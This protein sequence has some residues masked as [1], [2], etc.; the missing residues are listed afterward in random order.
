MT[1]IERFICHAYNG[2]NIG[3]A[4]LNLRKIGNVIIRLINISRKLQSQYNSVIVLQIGGNLL[5]ESF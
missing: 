3:V 5:Q 4:T 1:N 2:L